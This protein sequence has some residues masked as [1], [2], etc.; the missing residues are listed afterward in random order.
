MGQR[1]LDGPC[2]Q[3]QTRLRRQI[4]YGSMALSCA[5]QRLFQYCSRWYV[6]QQPYPRSVGLKHLSLDQILDGLDASHFM[7]QG[8]GR[9]KR[10]C[11]SR[12]TDANRVEIRLDS[13]IKRLC[14]IEGAS[15]SQ[16]NCPDLPGP[17][18]LSEQ[19][20]SWYILRRKCLCLDWL[21]L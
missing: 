9:V 7:P 6:K 19:L 14:C 11:H 5:N 3:A 12:Y 15:Q 4:Y 2:P 20:S 1:V 17:H 18:I 21:R 13:V 16:E 10:R 8:C